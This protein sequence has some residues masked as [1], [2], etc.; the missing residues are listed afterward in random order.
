M[1]NVH[2]RP[3]GHFSTLIDGPETSLIATADAKVHLRVDFDDDD[4]FIAGLVQAATDHLDAE[5]GILGRALITQR[6]QLT[7]PKFPA[8][9]H[10]DLPV[11][12]VQQVSSVT[13]YDTDNAQQTLA[14][15]QFRLIVNDESAIMELV[16]GAS[17]P[18]TY[19][20]S[21]A[22]AIQYDAGY[23]DTSADVPQAI[24]AAAMMLVGHWY[25]NREAVVT[26]TIATTLPLAAKTLLTPYRV[27]RSHI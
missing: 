7:M 25:E 22:I 17:W 16:E 15:D 23:G 6:W 19:A 5:H 10:I 18:N 21:D 27:T 3:D 4:A 12:R 2:H 11:G 20:R 26:G 9:N 8:D 14:N 1:A 13:Y 24:R